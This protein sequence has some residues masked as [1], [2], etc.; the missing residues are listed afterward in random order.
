MSVKIL[1]ITRGAA[2]GALYVALVLTFQP[3]SFGPVQ[4]RV[5]EALTL[6]PVL[7]AEAIPGLFVGCLIA[8]MFGS[9]GPL[10]IFLGS[11][12]TLIAAVISRYAPSLPLAAASPVVVNGLIVGC[13]LSFI[14]D[15]PCLM[16]AVYVAVGEAMAC[17]ALG[18]PL[19]KFL[20]RTKLIQKK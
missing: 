8:N 15:T 20:E 2:I 10:D 19:V 5:A 4:F 6:L 3:I 1:M 12:A 16:A 11:A 9:L 7:W 14:T 17:Y 13:Y 18:I